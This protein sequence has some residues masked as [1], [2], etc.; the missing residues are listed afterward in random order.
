MK[1]TLKIAIVEDSPID[2]DILCSFVREFL[3][4]KDIDCITDVFSNG[5]SIL[6][7]DNKYDLIFLDMYLPDML[8]V[9]ILNKL[10]ERGVE[11]QVVFSTSSKDFIEQSYEA[12]VLHYLVKPVDKRKISLVLTKFLNLRTEHQT[13]CLKIGR[14]KENFP[15][16]NIMY[17]E[18]FSHK[19]I[20][21]TLTD[22]IEISEPISEVELK[23]AQFSFVKVN[24]TTVVN[25][26][27]ITDVT[28]TDV[29]VSGNVLV[30]ISRNNKAEIKTKISDFK[31][32]N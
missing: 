7:S 20:V 1:N 14:D 5:S 24:R 22:E 11:S 23:L 26:R 16:A 21:H 15:V 19:C 31:N 17:V 32:K 10:R 9:D 4:E 27:Y 25:M 18:S 28:A 3:F 6:A 30:S 29:V 13:V 2:Q 8:G 12:E